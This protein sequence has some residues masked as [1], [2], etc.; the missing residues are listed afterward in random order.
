MMVTLDIDC[1]NGAHGRGPD[2]ATGI[3]RTLPDTVVF[4]LQGDGDCLAIGAEPFLNAMFRAENITIIML[5]NANYGTTGGQLAPTTLVGQVTTTTPQGRDVAGQG[6]PAH[7]AEL[8]STLKGVS[9]SARGALATASHYRQSKEYVRL[10]FQRQ[11]SAPGLSFVEII[12]ACPTDWRLSPAD[13]LVRIK[14][15]MLREFPL[16]IFKDV[17]APAGSGHVPASAA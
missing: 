11:M 5:N 3:K 16:G 8:A 14:D 2:I 13:S 9:F 12:C 4:T 1:I 7:A 17:G 15:E 6:Y 10:A